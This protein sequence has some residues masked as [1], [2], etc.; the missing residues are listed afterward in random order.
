MSMT[1]ESVGIGRTLEW[2]ED[3]GKDEEYLVF[4]KHVNSNGR[5]CWS[6]LLTPWLCV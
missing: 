2:Q 4:E 6:E 3:D 1:Q 5:M